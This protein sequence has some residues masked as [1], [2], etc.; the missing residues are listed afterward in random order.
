MLARPKATSSA[1]MS[2]DPPNAHR[3]THSEAASNSQFSVAHSVTRFSRA[4][5]WTSSSSRSPICRNA[6]AAVSGSNRTFV[7]IQ[8][9]KRSARPWPC[10]RPTTSS[11]TT[12]MIP[13]PARAA[14]TYSGLTPRRGIDTSSAVQ[15]IRLSTTA[16]PRPAVASANPAFGPLT[17]DSVISRYP[18]AEPAALPPG[19]MLDSALVLIWMRNIRIREMSELASP[20]AER[21][22][23]E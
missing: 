17:P 5:S 2:S 6:R 22:S 16:D 15:K 18:R 4:R 21:V 14:V 10:C 12:S 11:A 19:T 20:S 7:A 8:R 13:R 1:S 3:N 23:S 9:M